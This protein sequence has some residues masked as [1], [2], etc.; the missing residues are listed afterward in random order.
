MAWTEE[1]KEIREA[2]NKIM[3]ACGFSGESGTEGLF[4]VLQ[5]AVGSVAEQWEDVVEQSHKDGLNY[6]I[7]SWLACEIAKAAA[8]QIVGEAQP[9]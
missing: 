2:L 6:D 5:Q 9:Q 7:N 4:M 1:E 3:K 8:Q